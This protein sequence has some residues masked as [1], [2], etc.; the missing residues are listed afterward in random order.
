MAGE[1]VSQA[2]SQARTTSEAQARA[3]AATDGEAPARDARPP[4]RRD[5]RRP[6]W[7]TGAARAAVAVASA[8]LVFLAFPPDRLSLLLS[9]HPTTAGLWPFAPIGVAGFTL[10]VRGVRARTGAW[11]GLAFGLPFFLATLFGIIKIGPDGWI[12]LS[13]FQAL[14]MV[15]LGAGIAVATRLRGW[16]LWCAAL[17]V[18]EELVRGRAPLGGFPWAR[19]A[20]SQTSSPLTPY[21]ALG[22][23]PLVTFVTA[24]T[25]GLLAYAALRA[26]GVR[27][28]GA[29]RRWTAVGVA[30][31]AAALICAAGP[32]IPTPAGGKA[33]TVAVV[34]GNVPRLGLDFLGQRKAVLNNH[35][36]ATHDLAAR[37][38]AGQT[39]R[40]DLVIWPENASDLDPYTDQDARQTIDAAV[41]DVGVPVLVGAVIDASDG[42]HVENRGIV[43][44]PRTGPGE[45]YTKRHPVPFGEY[46]PMRDLLTKLITRFERIPND[47]LPGKRPGVLRLGPVSVGDVICFEVAYDGIVRDVSA[48]QLLVVQ[49]NNATYGH[50]SLPWQQVAMSRLRAVEH[51]RSVLVAAT[52]GITAVIGP[53][54]TVV[55]RSGEFAPYVR[56][57]RVPARTSRTLA[58]HLG[59]APEWLIALVGVAAVGIAAGRA[60]AA[61]RTAATGDDGGEER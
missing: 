34:Q 32:V 15:P 20:F 23:A 11:L 27:P 12:I 19:L 60:R 13:L 8:L 51:G 46:L 61:R 49:T 41:R 5:R 26:I 56:V 53:D 55:D 21:A 52:S 4:G 7:A 58:D 59:A 36:R 6:W 31:A 3:G 1:S 29:L 42:V 39:A 35:A 54:G 25:G 18:A 38:R 45:Y 14:Y 16:P 17:W 24:L 28:P 9:G 43:W 48:A 44:D 10:A 22:G 37:I 30:A 2:A 40:P 33:V 47:Y 57:A 50:T